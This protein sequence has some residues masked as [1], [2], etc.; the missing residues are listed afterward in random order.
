MGKIA[1]LMFVDHHTIDHRRFAGVVI[2]DMNESAGFDSVL[3]DLSAGFV[4]VRNRLVE[5]VTKS[6]VP[7]FRADYDYFAPA[8]TW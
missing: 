8:Q 3:V 2:I 6:I 5:H 7:V 1:L 4:H